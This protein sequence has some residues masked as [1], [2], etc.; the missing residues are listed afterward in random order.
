MKIVPVLAIPKMYI[1]EYRQSN[2]KVLVQERKEFEKDLTRKA[3]KIQAG[4]QN[5]DRYIEAGLSQEEIKRHKY[6][7]SLNSYDKKKNPLPIMIA[8]ALIDLFTVI[9]ILLFSINP[10]WYIELL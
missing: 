5:P 7:L 1:N 2:Q 10:E 9:S 8:H 4:A 3:L 6:L